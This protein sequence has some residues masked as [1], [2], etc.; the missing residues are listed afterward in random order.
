YGLSGSGAP[1]TGVAVPGRPIATPWMGLTATV[2][3]FWPRAAV[4]KTVRPARPPSR[5]ERRSPAVR[6]RFDS[7]AGGTASAW[8]PWGGSVGADLAEGQALVS[9][10]ERE[11]PLPFR[12]TL[13]D[14]RAE[15]YPGSRRPASYESRVRIEERD[16][17]RSE[18][19]ISMNHPL[20]RDGYV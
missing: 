10:G 2:E 11:V 8:V 16:G 12:L 4:R 15:T 9:F 14:F 18:H 19:L 5:E 13:L 1:A 6:V 20:H 7:P 3:T 17:T